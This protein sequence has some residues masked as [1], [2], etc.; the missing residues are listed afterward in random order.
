MEAIHKEVQDWQIVASTNYNNAVDEIQR[1]AAAKVAQA[2]ARCKEVVD[3][4][5]EKVAAQLV[6]AEEAGEM[7]SKAAIEEIQKEATTRVEQAEEAA[8]ARYN[9]IVEDLRGK[10]AIQIA[11]S[12]EAAQDATQRADAAVA[13]TE[14]MLEEVKTMVTKV[15]EAKAQAQA[16]ERAAVEATKRSEI[17]EEEVERR[18]KHVETIPE[19][20]I[21]GEEN[22][23]RLPQV[24]VETGVQ[25]M[26]SHQRKTG[27]DEAESWFKQRFSIGE[28]S[29][30]DVI[31]DAE[32]GISADRTI[33]FPS[34]RVVEQ[35]QPMEN[36]QQ[37]A[38][39][40]ASDRMDEDDVDIYESEDEA[41][42]T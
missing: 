8:R 15:M 5:Y 14:R 6:Q 18:R 10:A 11:R 3:E 21:R 30:G 29:E 17:A 37:G 40:N 31:F 25:E 39:Q 26:R 24:V 34:P 2:E 19:L 32:L 28:E 9:A 33:Q 12:E 4:V 35:H 36:R 27:V 13:N 41:K 1:E 16:A 42:V 20:I 22:V 7:R 38:L 23:K